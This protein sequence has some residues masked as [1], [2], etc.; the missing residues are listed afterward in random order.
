[1]SPAGPRRAVPT[2]AS[3]G[4]GPTGLQQ[5]AQWLYGA[6][7]VAVLA[8]PVRV[9]FGELPFLAGFVLPIVGY[10]AGLAWAVGRIRSEPSDA[11]IFRWLCG[12]AVVHAGM[13]GVAAVGLWIPYPA[14]AFM[15]LAGM[16]LGFL[17]GL[18]FVVYARRAGAY[19]CLSCL[20]V[21]WLVTLGWWGGVIRP[22]VPQRSSALRSRMRSTRM[23]P[24]ARTVPRTSTRPPRTT[25]S[26]TRLPLPI[27][28]SAPSTALPS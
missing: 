22:R 1:M 28:I 15:G 26:S 7:A 3:D 13:G 25:S 11:R 16:L 17:P 8:W 21:A 18:F 24:S 9:G 2:P 5:V 23:R 10:T 14:F 19:A 20:G 27:T 12:I 6:C 4:A